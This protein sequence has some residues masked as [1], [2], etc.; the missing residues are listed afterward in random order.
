MTRSTPIEHRW[1]RPL[2]SELADLFWLQ[3]RLL[4]ASLR[5]GD[6]RSRARVL[7]VLI[8]LISFLPSAAM[9]S[10]GLLITLRGTEPQLSARVVSVGFGFL[11]LIWA[12]APLTAQPLLEGLN[13]PRLLT[14]PISLR[15]LALGSLVGSAF[16]LLGLISL[17]FMASAV[18]G[19]A[20]GPV[21]GLAAIAASGLLLALMVVVKSVS[22]LLFDLLAEDRR[23][24]GLVSALTV[25][26]PLLVYLEQAGLTRPGVEG[27]PFFAAEALTTRLATWLPGG[28]YARALRAGIE[29]DPGSWTRSLLPFGVAL[30]AGLIVHQWLLWRLHQGELPQSRARANRS[31]VDDRSSLVSGRLDG[32]RWRVLRGL[33]RKDILSTRRSPLS[34]R[35]AFLPPL[36]AVL[37]FFVSRSGEMPTT[38]AILG[39]GVG[40]FCAFTV[41]SIGTNSFGLIDHLGVASLL[42]SPAP[43]RS[44]LLSH[45]IVL[46]ALALAL[47]VFGGA[48]TALG[49][50]DP[51]ALVA[52]LAAAL[53][54]GLVLTGIAHVAS[55]L[56]PVYMDLERGQNQANQRSFAASFLM[57]LGGP[58]ALAAPIGL[59]LAT[60]FLA[61]AWLPGALAA[62]ALYCL[63]AYGLLLELATRLLPAREERI[64]RIIVEDR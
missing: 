60:V 1:P 62:A 38:P 41:A 55:V 37:G 12:A 45:G 8:L 46:L 48:G 24:R 31:P 63:V 23:L 18:A 59:P 21:S 54:V 57:L 14:Q 20:R 27:M 33:L 16:G 6:S 28:W 50:G 19:A 13:L 9:L 5:R 39:L 2:R 53:G 44:I 32:A 25:G 15:G 22:T 47:A 52:A 42:L 34:L 26:L 49:T 56:F 11:F 30:P 7:T 58:V 36:F 3:R 51:K 10:I 61:P 43:R 64:L 4:A 17:P 29:A 35:L 40:G